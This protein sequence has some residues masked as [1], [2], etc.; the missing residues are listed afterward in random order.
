MKDILERCRKLMLQS[1]TEYGSVL[2]DL[3][4]N[5]PE[6]LAKSAGH[7]TRTCEKLAF[8]AREI[9]SVYAEKGGGT[10]FDPDED[11]GDLLFP[12]ELSDDGI[13]HIRLPMF[14]HR[15]KPEKTLLHP[16]LAKTLA[17]FFRNYDKEHGGHRRYE[18]GTLAF[19]FSFAAYGVGYDIDNLN[20]MEYKKTCDDI[21]SYFLPN[22]GPF[23]CSRFHVARQGDQTCVD[24]YF[25]PDGLLLH[26]MQKASILTP[27]PTDN[28]ATNN[29]AK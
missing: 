26:W 16:I 20:D 4:K 17:L 19:V 2:R 12:C 18:R 8:A 5:N 15:T 3:S 10:S 24:S 13:F 28:L 1:G 25:I 22:D 23:R 27:A 7:F 6:S 21:I 29:V 11:T 14:S 9:S